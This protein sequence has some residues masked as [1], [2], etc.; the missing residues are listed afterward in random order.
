M[1]FAA[2]LLILAINDAQAIKLSAPNCDAADDACWAKK[3]FELRFGPEGCLETQK[4]ENDW[5]N[6]NKIIMGTE[7]GAVTPADGTQPYNE[8][9]A[10]PLFKEPWV[11]GGDNIP[12]AKRW[13]PKG[14]K[15][16]AFV[17]PRVGNGATATVAPYI[18]LGHA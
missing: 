6:G 10:N 17:P 16:P 15:E 2:A 3:N 8:R 11:D 13:L 7:A 14:A 1:K 12:E 4:K 9:K 18:G 5:T